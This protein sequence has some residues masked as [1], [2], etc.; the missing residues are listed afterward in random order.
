M[1]RNQYASLKSMIN[2]NVDDRVSELTNSLAI[3]CGAVEG[4]EASALAERLT[5]YNNSFTGISLS[6]MTIFSTISEKYTN[7]CLTMGLH[8]SGK[9]R[10]RIVR[11]T[12][13]AVVMVG[14]QCLS[15]IIIL[16]KKQIM[17]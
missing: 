13:Q 11:A 2:S 8:L 3:F 16:L 5:D 12:Q 1:N 17:F 9:L 14:A 6:I 10:I 4:E 15:I 7:H